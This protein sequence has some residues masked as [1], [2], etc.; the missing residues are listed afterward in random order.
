MK[1][2]Y[3]IWKQKVSE[4][5]SDKWF[6]KQLRINGHIVEKD[7]EMD[8]LAKEFSERKH[9]ENPYPPGGLKSK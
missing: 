2:V 8:Q 1:S 5:K 9:K 3:E 7:P 6:E 4:D